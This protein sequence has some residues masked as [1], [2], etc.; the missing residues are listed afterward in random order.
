MTSVLQA[1]PGCWQLQPQVPG[2]RGGQR[3]ASLRQPVTGWA[4]RLVLGWTC[5]PA[6]TPGI[7]LV[8]TGDEASA[9]TSS[10]LVTAALQW[11]HLVPCLCF[12]MCTTACGS[13]V[14]R[15]HLGAKLSDISQ[16]TGETQPENRVALVLSYAKNTM[17]AKAKPEWSVLR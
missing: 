4:A 10:G 6:V 7:F 5:G 1:L 3:S 13:H 2:E 8:M 14:F 15:K 12:K 9:L 17:Y 11:L 16:A